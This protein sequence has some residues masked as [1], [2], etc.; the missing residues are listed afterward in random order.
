[1]PSV[2]EAQKILSQNKISQQ[3]IKNEVL[4]DVFAKSKCD[5]EI[6]I[7]EGKPAIDGEKGKVSYLFKRE[8]IANSREKEKAR[9]DFKQTGYVIQVK[10]G[11]VLAEIF[12]PKQGQDGISVTGEVIAAIQYDPIE[13]PIGKNSEKSDKNPNQ[14]IASIDGVVTVKNNRVNGEQV[15]IIEN[16]VDFETGNIDFNGSV[17]I[18][19]GVKAG[20]VVKAVGDITVKEIVEDALIDS[21]GNV[22]LKG[23]FVGYG[24]GELTTQ[25]DAVIEFAEN[26]KIY[27]GGDVKVS[28]SLLHCSVEVDGKIFVMGKR[29]VVGGSIAASDSIEVQSA[30]SDAFKKTVLCIG[31]KREIREKMEQYKV[32]GQNNKAN[33]IK[34][35]CILARF[36]QLKKIKKTLPDKDQAQYSKILKIKKKLIEESETLATIKKEIDEER[37]KFENAFVKVKEKAYPGVVVEIGDAKLTVN[38][39]IKNII[40]RK[41]GDSIKTLQ[42]I[43]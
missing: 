1:M 31:L 7:A 24:K 11:L 25:G 37:L 43:K 26:Q 5:Q 8:N 21:Q 41:D 20:F 15:I 2:E 12:P 36:E 3:M 9:V 14:V 30:G 35:D 22:I 4:E 17:I 40:F 29:G 42:S 34:I 19:G 13:L 33:T 10:K 27:A 16:D 23:G 38:E 6:L 32:D 28:D 18:K 39:T